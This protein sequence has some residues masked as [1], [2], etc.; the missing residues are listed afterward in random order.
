MV[1]THLIELSLRKHHSLNLTFTKVSTRWP[2]VT[3]LLI[4][5]CH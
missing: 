1:K 2:Q 4:L 5:S 3:S